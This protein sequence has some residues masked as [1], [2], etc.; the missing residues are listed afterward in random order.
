VAIGWNP[1]FIQQDNEKT[2]VLPND[3]EFLEATA[4]GGWNINLVC[5]P[6]NSPDINILDLGLFAALQSLFQKNLQLLF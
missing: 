5:Q 2:H 1:I 6:L 4:I 3:H